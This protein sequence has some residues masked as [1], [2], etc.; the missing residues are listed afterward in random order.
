M[1]FQTNNFQFSKYNFVFFGTP[2]FSKIVL[3]KMKTVGLI[4]SLIVT[5]EDKPVGRK[6]VITPPP[7][8]VFA[9]EN[10]IPY[11]QFKSLKNADLVEKIKSYSK[12]SFD[13]FVVCAYGKI[14]PKNI[15]DL[16]KKGTL[17]IHPS[18]LPKLRGASPIQS[19][20]LEE[21]ETGVTIMLLDEE[22]DHGDIL[23]QKVLK[24]PEDIKEFP[25]YESKLEIVLAD[26]GAK[27]LIETIPKWIDGEIQAK[28][29]EHILA[30]F[31]KKIEKEDAFLD[32]KDIPEKN[33]RKIMAYEKWP[34]A[35][36]FEERNGQKT[37][38]IVKS[39]H[40]EKTENGDTLV[41]DRII[42][43]GKKEIDYKD[44]IANK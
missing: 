25:T 15:L 2:E 17:N 41:I 6:L 12:E 35:F 24:I 3:E 28:P 1:N 27:L 14:I 34:K 7:V 29:Q 20:I 42:P 37:R 26:V 30:T 32:L 39:A 44:W 22:M 5:G 16:P 11:L 31:C 4:P 36:F 19:A 13:F 40:I 38:I 23:S 8:K 33:L 21:K 9:E 10:K 18:L 43:E